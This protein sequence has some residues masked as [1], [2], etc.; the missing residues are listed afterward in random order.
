MTS[1]TT[2]LTTKNSDTKRNVTLR[3]RKY[4]GGH[5]FGQ[6]KL[7]IKPG[8]YKKI[9]TTKIGRIKADVVKWT[10][11]EKEV[12]YWEC[13]KCFEDVLHEYWLEEKIEKLFGVKCKEYESTLPDM[14]GMVY[15][16]NNN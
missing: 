2:K 16:Q 4:A 11:K 12:E 8:E 3:S 6:F 9:G 1:S 7:P 10:G 5:Y 15:I 14:P 13:N